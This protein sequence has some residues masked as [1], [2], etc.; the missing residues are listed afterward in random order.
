MPSAMNAIV[1]LI[2]AVRLASGT[3]S[4]L[5]LAYSGARDAA[6]TVTTVLAPLVHD[7][8]APADQQRTLES[9]QLSSA[10][11][12]Y[13]TASYARMSAAAYRPDLAALAGA[14]SRLYD[15][16]FDEISDVE[17]QDR[18][19]R[20]FRDEPFTPMTAYERLLQG[21]LAEISERMDHRGRGPMLA[22]LDELHQYQL[23]S[24]RQRDQT[25]RPTEVFRICRGKGGMAASAF[26][27][28]L[29]PEAG[30]G[31]ARL[32]TR[33]GW[34]M[35]SIDD[36]SDADLDLLDGITTPATLG[37]ETPSGIVARIL[38]LRP[39]LLA[40][41]GSGARQFISL[42]YV[43]LLLGVAARRLRGSRMT[44]IGTVGAGPFRSL[45]RHSRSAVPPSRSS[46]RQPH[47][48]GLST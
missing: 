3:P 7:A 45:L 16:L 12:T 39:Q 8:I 47:D 22:A 26:F 42:M 17:A 40:F 33:I 43:H 25:I 1:R 24:L 4:A 9:L 6:S 27:Y 18:L 5:K 37:L 21:I 32:F 38:A 34:V 29:T 41:H 2:Q 19:G 46:A 31:E 10:R 23:D 20:L 48:A 13:L 44:A 11:F 15:D 35:Q 14:F 28:M 30:D 36:Q